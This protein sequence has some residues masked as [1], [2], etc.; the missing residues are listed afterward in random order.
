ML[1]SWQELRL[2]LSTFRVTARA[3]YE[4]RIIARTLQHDLRK[5]IRRRSD[6]V[7]RLRTD[8]APSPTRDTAS[9]APRQVL[10][11]IKGPGRHPTSSH[12]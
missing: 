9:F 10:R 1:R 5:S 7:V 11:L 6:E 4:G 2:D 12:I 8:H 3:P